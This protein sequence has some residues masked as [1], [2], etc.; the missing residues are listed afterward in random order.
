MVMLKTQQVQYYRFIQSNAYSPL[1]ALIHI[2]SSHLEM[3]P[4][5]DNLSKI[6][7]AMHKN[8]ANR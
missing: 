7:N 4:N 8:G 3:P 1:N 2:A 5:A 6:N